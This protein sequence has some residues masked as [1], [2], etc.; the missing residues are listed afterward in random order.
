MLKSTSLLVIALICVN[1]RAQNMLV[2][3]GFESNPPSSLGNN[4]GW[5]IAPWVM[6]GTAQSNVI[7]VD[8]PGGFS[9]GPGAPESDASAPGAGIPQHYLDID[10]S[11]GVFYQ[12]FTPECSGTVEFGGSFSTRANQGGNARVTLRQGTG[13]SGP[14]VATRVVALA[15]GTFNTTH[16]TPFSSTAA[17]TASITYSIVVAMDN[18]LNF[19]NGFVT[20]RS[21]CDAHACIQAA[22]DDEAICD[23]G[24]AVIVTAHVT[25]T[26]GHPIQ[27]I[28]IGAGPGATYTVSPNIVNAPLNNNQSTTITVTVSG[29]NS[30]QPICLTFLLQDADG[31]TCCSI[32]RCFD[33]RC[34]CLKVTDINVGC[35]PGPAAYAISFSV[36]NLTNG[37][38]QQ[39]FA[40]PSSGSVSPQLIATNIG[41]GAIISV[42]LH[43]S[44]VSAGQTVCIILQ[45]TGPETACCTTRV[46]VT[47]PPILVNCD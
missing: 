7:K 21:D 46:C 15:A 39:L 27:Y 3:G 43:L 6:T 17:V 19:D 35:D 37:T 25:N 30:M 9:Y 5:S 38:I 42:T 11:D 10:Q 36:Q 31:Q 4:P 8:G 29:A 22:V 13:T 33:V 34:A 18:Q 12:T 47:L 2:N 1:A 23:K 45:A 41:A 20:T 16:W 14:L 32:T 44:N 40:I 24:G 26:S 28:L